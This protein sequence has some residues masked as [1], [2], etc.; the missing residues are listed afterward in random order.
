MASCLGSNVEISGQGPRPL[1]F[2][3]L[4][5]QKWNEGIRELR[6]SGVVARDVSIVF[7]QRILNHI[8]LLCQG[9]YDYLERLPDNIL[10]KII[11]LLKVKDVALLGQVSRRFRMVRP[12]QNVKFIVG[13][14]CNSEKF[15]E[16]IVRTD[17]ADFN[18]DME[19]IA[20]AMG[21]R[22]T[23]FTF[24]HKNSDKEQHK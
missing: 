23:Y 7:G 12:S 15:W 8:L 2:S 10:L 21:W 18:S 11:C 1:D 16:Q 3:Q 19:G 24:F 20:S 4:V 6:R 17:C 9:K 5:I 14:L 22:M 13:V